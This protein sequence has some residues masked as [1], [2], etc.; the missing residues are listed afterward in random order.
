MLGLLLFTSPSILRL[1]GK[2]VVGHPTCYKFKCPVNRFSSEPVLLKLSCMFDIEG[3]NEVW[4]S[5][6]LSIYW[7]CSISFSSLEVGQSLAK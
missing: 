7:S 3:V 1:R 6:K 2:N 5:P 4:S